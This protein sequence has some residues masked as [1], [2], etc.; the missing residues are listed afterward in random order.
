MIKNPKVSARIE[1]YK[2]WT[3]E[4]EALRNIILECGLTEELKWY[5]PCYTFNGKNVI[6]LGGFKEYCALNF[7]KGSLLKDPEHILIQQT[8]HVQATRQLRFTSIQEI[9]DIKDIIKA[10][11]LEA[12][13]IEKQG[14]EISYKKTDEFVIPEELKLRFKENKKLKEAFK[15]LTP[16]RQRGY[17]LY[18]SSAKQTETRYAR[19]DKYT[20]QILD[21]K[22]L[23]KGK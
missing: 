15:N 10:Y 14:L 3:E 13:D 7:F 12:L 19:I 23:E 16:G 6:V 8:E 22:G 18:F 2:P 21:G 4:L 17:L 11:V 1:K 5:Q 20:K 9:E